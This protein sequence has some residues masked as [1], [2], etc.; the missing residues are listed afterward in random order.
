MMTGCVISP[1]R[2]LGG[3]AT[4]TPTPT[5]TPTPTPVPTATPTPTP[6]APTN[7]LYVSNQNTNTIT[8]FS[9]GLSVNGNVAP[10]AAIVG[11]ATTLDNPQYLAFDSA[12]DRLFVANVST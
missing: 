1:R 11:G 4:P 3:S 9:N 6:A 12:H 5:A 7:R 2:T 10:S 8:V